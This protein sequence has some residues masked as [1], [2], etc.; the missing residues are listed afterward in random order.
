MRQQS[1]FSL[2]LL[3]GFTS[4]LVCN[5]LATV[6]FEFVLVIPIGL[7]MGSTELKIEKTFKH[8]L[9]QNKLMDNHQTLS[10][11]FLGSLLSNLLILF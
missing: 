6:T 11:A 8:L 4:N 9:L 5:I 2:K 7:F 10:V 3:G 1:S